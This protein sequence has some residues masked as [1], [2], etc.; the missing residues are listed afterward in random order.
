M[1]SP[2]PPLIRLEHHGRI[3]LLSLSRQ[4]KRNAMTPDMFAQLHAL[5][6]PDHAIDGLVLTGDGPV[7]CGGFDLKLAAHTPGTLEILLRELARTIA[8]LAARSHPVVIAAHGAAIA[9]GCALLAAADLTLGTPD[10]Q[11]GYP[12][13]RLGLSPAI[14]FPYLRTLIHDGPARERLL[15]SSLIPGSEA[16]RIGLLHHLEPTP[17]ACR[18]AALSACQRLAAKPRHAFAA[19]KQLLRELHNAAATADRALTVSL[20]TADTPEC[21]DRLTALFPASPNA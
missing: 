9:G 11:Y 13:V 17:D 12:V 14:S 21:H 19:T 6:P 4:G 8:A 2:P 5:L 20:N 18:Q 16:H 15:D 1:T 7:F 10:G 3:A